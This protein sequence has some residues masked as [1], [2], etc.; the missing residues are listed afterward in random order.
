MKVLPRVLA[1]GVWLTAC[2]VGQVISPTPSLVDL[3]DTIHASDPGTRI[4]L[5]NGAEV[6]QN[7]AVTFYRGTMP[8]DLTYYEASFMGPRGGETIEFLVTAPSQY[9]A[10]LS[11]GDVV[12]ATPDSGLAWGTQTILPLWEERDAPDGPL[13]NLIPGQTFYM[14]FRAAHDGEEFRYGFIRGS[15]AAD[16]ESMTFDQVLYESTPGL[17]IVVPEPSSLLMGSIGV[18]ALAFRRRG[19]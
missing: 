18:L 16:G 4:D 14:G 13:G 9:A 12:D 10:S 1:A 6:Y 15:F 19:R 7:I 11:W 8:G 2:A 17:G 3:P 5:I